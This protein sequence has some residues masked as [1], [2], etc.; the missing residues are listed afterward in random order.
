[1]RVKKNQHLCTDGLKPEGDARQAYLEA[2]ER[3]LGWLESQTPRNPRKI[4]PIPMPVGVLGD[5][6]QDGHAVQP[7]SDREAWAF[8]VVT[9]RRSRRKSK[10]W[11][12]APKR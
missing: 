11:P 4:G 9:P 2:T 3:E 7:V 1:M 8:G 5:T 10:P 6:A 12:R